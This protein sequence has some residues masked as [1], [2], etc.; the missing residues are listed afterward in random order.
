M[1]ALPASCSSLYSVASAAAVSVPRVSAALKSQ[2]GSV[3]SE[4]RKRKHQ[5]IDTLRYHKES[6]VDEVDADICDISANFLYQ[7]TTHARDEKK[8]FNLE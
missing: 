5:Q 8:D 6:C 3:L 7:Y 2:F 4:V 1:L